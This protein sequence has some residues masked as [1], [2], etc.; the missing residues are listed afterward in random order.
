MSEFSEALDKLRNIGSLTD[1]DLQALQSTVDELEGRKD[2]SHSYF[3][4]FSHSSPHHTAHTHATHTSIVREAEAATVE[5][6]EE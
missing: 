6:L 1:K 3:S 5:G 2:G 4:Q